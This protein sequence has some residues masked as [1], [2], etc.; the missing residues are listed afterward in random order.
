MKITR[1]E[2]GKFDGVLHIG[3]SLCSSCKDCNT[4]DEAVQKLF[5][6]FI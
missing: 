1:N 4:I 6:P 5:K 3:T 2:N